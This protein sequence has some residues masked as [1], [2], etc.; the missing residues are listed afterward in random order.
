MGRYAALG[1]GQM[2]AVSRVLNC[3][4]ILSS[5]AVNFCWLLDLYVLQPTAAPCDRRST[6]HTASS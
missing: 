1:Q 6:R 2:Y 3:L 4:F 5:S